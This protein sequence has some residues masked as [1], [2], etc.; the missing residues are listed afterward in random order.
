[1]PHSVADMLSLLAESNPSLPNV[2]AFRKNPGSVAHNDSIG[3]FTLTG[4]TGEKNVRGLYELEIPRT[5]PVELTNSY[6]DFTYKM[7]ALSS[8]NK[9]FNN[10]LDSFELTIWGNENADSRNKAVTIYSPNSGNAQRTIFSDQQFNAN[11]NYFK[12]LIDAAESIRGVA[13]TSR[14]KS[15]WWL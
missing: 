4:R 5:R 3:F 12:K 8:N 14:R 1:M 6:D 13:L 2:R 10:P 7:T 15:E 11:I 9:S